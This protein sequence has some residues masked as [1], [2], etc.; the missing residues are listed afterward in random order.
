MKNCTRVYINKFGIHL[1]G[2]V[3]INIQSEK[4]ENWQPTRSCVETV[5]ACSVANVRAMIPG[6]L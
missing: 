3:C 6:V 2:N 5:L 4:K 1:H